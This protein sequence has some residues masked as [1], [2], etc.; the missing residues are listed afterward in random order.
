MKKC[1]RKFRQALDRAIYEGRGK[2]FVWLGSI[3]VLAFAVMLLLA[4][5][6]DFDPQYPSQVSMTPEQASDSAFVAENPST[7]IRVL[8]LMLDPGAMVGAYEY[9]NVWLQLL[10]VLVGATFFTSFL[11]G[12][13]GNLL[14]RRVD[15]ITNG[16]YSYDFEDHILIL[17]SSNMLENLLKQIGTSDKDIVIQTSEDV[18]Q[19]RERVM[20]YTDPKTMKHVYVIFGKRTNHAALDTLRVAKA[21][22]IYVIG[23]DDEPQHDGLNLKCWHHI[24]Q[25]CAGSVGVKD[26]YLVLDRMTTQNVFSYRKENAST[27]SLRLNIVSAVETM[28][29]G[30]LVSAKVKDV[31][32]PTLDRNGIGKDSDV[33][34]HFVIVGMTQVSYAMAITAAHICHF[35]NFME[36]GK[37]TKITFIQKNIK[38]ELDF[39]MGRFDSLMDLSYA[40]V[41]SWDAAGVKHVKELYPKAEYINPKYSDEKGFLDIEWEF[42][43]AGIENPHVRNYIRD[44]VAKDGYSEYLSFAFCGHEAEDNVAA[45]LYLPQEVYAKHDIPVYVYQP[46]TRWVLAT[47]Q[48]ADR[49]NNLYPF[50][51]REE[52]FDPQLERLLWAKRIKYLYAHIDD[53]TGMGSA[54]ELDEGWYE[55][56][57]QYIRQQSN[58]YSANSIPVKFRSIGIDPAV[59]ASISHDD[60]LLLAE[61]EHNRWNIERLLMGTSPLSYEKR[62]SLLKDQLSANENISKAA[63]AEK[64]DLKNNHFKHADI[65]PY[66]ELLDSSKQY[67]I[68]IVAHLIDVIKK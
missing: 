63:K 7:A 8:E 31:E 48:Q 23:E 14:S 22:S 44:C 56:E 13:I 26:C 54:A 17:G 65:A 16:Q 59:D 58:V 53:Y 19:V 35:P 21:S 5:L 25:K 20:L 28:A 41:V 24:C 4:A 62:M 66:G 43:D 2:Q 68:N 42:I 1:W 18:E 46:L 6:V 12:T 45:S 27:E 15:S 39:W 37:K 49:Y 61:V 38:E 57:Q 55:K 51:M 47:A 29:Q 40:E 64:K 34:V 32:Y 60:V 3:L 33:N 36:K 50:G 52:C 11:I 67:D 10:I 9:G 30:V